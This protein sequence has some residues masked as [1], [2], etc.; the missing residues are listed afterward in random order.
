MTMKKHALQAFRSACFSLRSPQFQ[1]RCFWSGVRVSAPRSS[2]VGEVPF[3]GTPRHQS[4]SPLSTIKRLTLAVHAATSAFNDPT[5]ADS[6]AVLGEV[7]GH[8]ALQSMK[9]KMLSHPVGREIMQNQPKV[10]KATM[11]IDQLIASS[12]LVS[13]RTNTT[14]GQAYGK[15]LECHGFDPDQ[16]DTVKYIEDPELAYVMLRYRQ[17]HDFW[18]V[19]T[20]L[21]PTILG[22]LG[23]K[24]LE[25]LQTGLPVAALSATVGSFRLDESERKIL[26]NYYLPWAVRMSQQAEH[27]M[28]VYYEEEMNT[29][30]DELRSRLK[31]E[32]APTISEGWHD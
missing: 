25:L 16:R 5:R 17:C 12:K 19:L 7:T 27:L 2:D 10:S 23:L 4:P 28:N 13:D 14:F 24:W 32:P 6:V 9:E 18:H 11:P 31:I 20:G 15:F 8:V 1:L 26:N 29:P 30:L 21:P 3:Y 22:E